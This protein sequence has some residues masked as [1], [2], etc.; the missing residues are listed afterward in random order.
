LYSVIPG[1][2]HLYELKE[3]VY[4]KPYKN[5]EQPPKS[6]SLCLVAKEKVSQKV[7]LNGEDLKTLFSMTPYFYRTSEENKARLN[8]VDNI[9]LTVEFTILQYRRKNG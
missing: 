6:E 2:N 1:E 9:D 7:N 4:D 5:D 3:I 8:N